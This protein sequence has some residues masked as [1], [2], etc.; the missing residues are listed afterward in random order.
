MTNASVG[1]GPSSSV[2][3]VRI[4]Q[5]S[6]P[7]GTQPVVSVVCV[8]YNHADF[9]QDCLDGILMQE[10]TFP[11]EIIVHDDASTDGTA[12]CLKQYADAHPALFRLILQDENQF[13]KNVR[14]TPIAIAAAKGEFVAFCDGDD[15]WTEAHKL[16]RQVQHL[17]DWPQANLCFH[18]MRILAKNSDPSHN[19]LL[20]EF[21]LK[22]T[23]TIE[24]LMRVNFMPNSSVVARR[25]AIAVTPDWFPNI[26]MNDWPRWI[27]ACEGACAAALD[28]VMGVYRR[29]EGGIWSGSRREAQLSANLDFYC[30]MA[31]FASPSVQALAKANKH[32][33]VSRLLKDA[34]GQA[35]FDRIARHVVLGRL[36]RI[37][38]R[39]V[40]PALPD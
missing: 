32:S 6:W 25:Q 13:S 39:F 23:Y 20:P 33:L 30:V 36:I 15:Y 1:V 24:D 38:K 11:V 35:K 10:T 9:I 4:T 3:P 2:S 8:T 12:A 17:R 26:L 18:R 16:Q 31:I 28:E 7:A 29:H 37:W 14:P 22:P 34:E 19:R 27:L 21:D 40:N 5:Q